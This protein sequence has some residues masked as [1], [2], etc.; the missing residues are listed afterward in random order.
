MGRAMKLKPENIEQAGEFR[1]VLR[2]PEFTE[3]DFDLCRAFEYLDLGLHPIPLNG[4][5]AAIPWKKYQQVQPRAWEIDKWFH[6]PGQHGIGLITGDLNRLEDEI[7]TPLRGLI[8]VDA[9]TRE[10]GRWAWRHFGPT[11]LISFTGG[12]GV[13]LIYEYPQGEIIGN[14]VKMWGRQID[15]RAQGGY[16]AVCPTV[17]PK[18][19]ER[20]GW[21]NWPVDVSEVPV[22]DSSKLPAKAKVAVVQPSGDPLEMADRARKYIAKIF[23]IEGKGGDRQLFRAACALIQKFNLPGEIALEELR[24]WN[25]QGNAQPEWPDDRL[26]YKIREA[27]RLRGGVLLK[28]QEE[29]EER[30]TATSCEGGR[31][32]VPQNS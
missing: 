12:G 27:A 16:I 24:R 19:G 30:M 23:S 20:Y 7:S 31:C 2:E 4:K 10:E 17:H 11:P 15:L 26:V 25:G 32:S 5:V 18:T 14:R 8:A 3:W 6:K 28:R 13:H 9:E 1:N 29:F 22:F 21:L